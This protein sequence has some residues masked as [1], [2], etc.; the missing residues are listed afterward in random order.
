[1]RPI[2]ICSALWDPSRLGW[3]VTTGGGA[4]VAARFVLTCPTQTES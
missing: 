3:D 1:M 4:L 2:L